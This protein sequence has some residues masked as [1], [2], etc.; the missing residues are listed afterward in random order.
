MFFYLEETLLDLE[1]NK[2][3]LS[4]NAMKKSQ[5]KG[6]LYYLSFKCKKEK[7]HIILRN[8]SCFRAWNLFLYEHVKHFET[9]PR[10]L[11]ILAFFKFLEKKIFQQLPT[12]CQTITH[13]PH[14]GLNQEMV[15]RS[16]MS[17]QASAFT[18]AYI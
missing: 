8:C 15:L 13:A 2:S 6:L 7:A 4:E 5:K 17:K 10:N 9:C 3:E 14:F 11:T 16:A 18:H 1:A 12:I